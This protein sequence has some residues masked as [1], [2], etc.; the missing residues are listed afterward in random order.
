[1]HVTAIFYEYASDF[2]E[3]YN[4]RPIYTLSDCLTDIILVN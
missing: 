2:H 3:S 1:M 4:V